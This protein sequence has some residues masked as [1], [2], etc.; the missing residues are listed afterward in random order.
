ME[1]TQ[2]DI[3]Y[4]T[5]GLSGEQLKEREMKAGTQ[6]RLILD[7]FRMHPGLEF[8]PFQVQAHLNLTRTPITSIR[9][10]ITTLTGLGYLR[11]T[12]VKRM[13]N[14]GVENN[15]WRLI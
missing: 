14:Y 6:N 1:A 15:C 13:G 3:F 8:T 9:R 7:F 4:N 5:T 11:M 2:L 10:S 12:N